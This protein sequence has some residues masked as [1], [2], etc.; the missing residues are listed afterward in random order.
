M[1]FGRGGGML[2][3]N[4]PLILHVFVSTAFLYG[5]G[6]FIHPNHNTCFLRQNVVYYMCSFSQYFE[7]QS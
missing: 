4:M 3:P 6:I 2:L 1:V 5:K 7:S